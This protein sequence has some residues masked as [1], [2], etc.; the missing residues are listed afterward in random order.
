VRH[1]RKAGTWMVPNPDFIQ[2][3]LK[4]LIELIEAEGFMVLVNQQGDYGSHYIKVFSPSIHIGED[5]KPN[6]APFNTG[7][8]FRVSDHTPREVFPRHLSIDPKNDC[9][10]LIWRRCLREYRRHQQSVLENSFRFRRGARDRS[11][12]YYKTK[13]RRKKNRR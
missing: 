7:M 6:K 4:R 1:L 9:P 11:E 2:S 5:L 13:S 8:H 12:Q 10:D 3:R